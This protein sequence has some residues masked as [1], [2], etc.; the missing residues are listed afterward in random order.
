MFI[1]LV[2]PLHGGADHLLSQHMLQHVLLTTLEPPLIVLGMTPAMV[3]P[4]RRPGVL[5]H[6]ARIGSLPLLATT[7][8]IINMCSGTSHRSTSSP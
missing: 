5:S 8:F 6:L 7:V 2:S 3:E 1:A 4:L